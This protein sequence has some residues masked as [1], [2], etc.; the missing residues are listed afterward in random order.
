[1]IQKMSDIPSDSAE[2]SSAK[3]K[4][5]PR[6]FDRT[7]ALEQALEVFWRRGYEPASISELCVAMEINPPSL[8]AAF[9]S[10]MQLFMEAVSYYETTYWDATWDKMAENPDIHS[11]MSDFFHDAAHILTSRSTPCGCLVISAATNVSVESEKINNALKALRKESY[12]WFLARI[13]RGIKDGQINA[14]TDAEGLA[15]A[16][17]A[18]LKGMS[19]AARDGTSHAMLDRSVTVAMAMLSASGIA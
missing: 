16:L 7:K 6:A 4:G 15:T 8:Y 14:D 2:I 9:G 19:L 13:Q 17:Y 12:D 11:A 1:M 5:R 3:G 18:V 10:K